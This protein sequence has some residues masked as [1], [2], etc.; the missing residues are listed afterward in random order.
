MERLDLGRDKGEPRSSEDGW[1]GRRLWEKWK[2]RHAAKKRRL[3]AMSRRRRILRRTGVIAT[4]ML[5]VLAVFVVTAVVGFA[6]VGF[7]M[8]GTSDQGA[9]ARWEP[10]G[11]VGIVLR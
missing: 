4:W 11:T 10:R 5:G 2:K 6:V 7:A 3:A 1:V 8:G 9:F